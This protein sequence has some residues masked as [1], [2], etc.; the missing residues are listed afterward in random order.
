MTAF[1][2]LFRAIVGAGA[3]TALAATTHAANFT[4]PRD[5]DTRSDITCAEETAFGDF[6]TD[7]LKKSLGAD[8][9]LADC[10]VIRGNRIHAKGS[11]FDAAAAASEI[12]D[13]AMAIQVEVSGTQLLEILE[14]AVAQTPASAPQF[15]Q[16]AGVR[17]E[18]DTTKPAGQRIVKLTSNGAALDFS[19][20]YRI[21]ATENA[22]AASEALR[23]A[24]RVEGQP[25]AL[26]GLLSTHIQNVGVG[27]IK[28]LGRIKI[29]R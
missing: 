7:A 25:V 19:R 1:P 3:L 26:A 20:T 29:K 4:L 17:M 14:A 15:L 21:A 12:A 5:L 8:I 22:V 27:D 28:V 11:T 2:M 9:G 18:V 16:I 10:S 13:G 6:V 24:K 23:S